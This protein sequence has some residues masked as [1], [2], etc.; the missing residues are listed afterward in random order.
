MGLLALS[1]LGRERRV[2]A[3]LT[4]L[5]AR[6]GRS[7]NPKRTNR[8]IAAY[9]RGDPWV[10]ANA[11]L[12]AAELRREGWTSQLAVLVTGLPMPP[13]PKT[14]VTPNVLHEV[15]WEAL[16]VPGLPAEAV[17]IAAD[18]VL[19]LL[20]H[21]GPDT[22]E[23]ETGLP[24][25]AVE[26]TLALARLRQGR[27]AEV[28]PLCAGVLDTP[29]PGNRA[30]VLATIVMARRALGQPYGDLLTRARVLAPAA[31]LVAEAGALRPR[32]AMHGGFVCTATGDNPSH[33]ASHRHR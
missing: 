33:Q 14:G 29:D 21:Y 17:D 9:N 5:A 18:R 27:F 28:E 25:G 16:I 30:T 23:P 11:G 6:D 2:R 31:D 8:V 3:D 26:H 7:P 1:K 12:L 19:W 22:F 20:D 13:G 4:A 24:R 15:V 32:L 10:L